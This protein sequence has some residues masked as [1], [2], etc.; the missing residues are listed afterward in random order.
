[1]TFD[2]ESFVEELADLLAEKVRTRDRI[3]PND[4]RQMVLYHGKKLAHKIL[5]DKDEQEN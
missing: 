2:A 1:M 3:Q 5:N 4:M